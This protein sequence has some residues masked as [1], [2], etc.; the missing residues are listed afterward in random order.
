MRHTY[1]YRSYKIYIRVDVRPDIDCCSSCLFAAFVS[2]S[3]SYAWGAAAL[4]HMYDHLND[5]S[6]SGDRQ[7]CWIYGHF[8]SVAECLTDPDYDEISPRAC[9]WIAMK[10]SLKSLPASMS[11]TMGSHCGQTPTKEGGAQ[12]GYVHTIPP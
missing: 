1:A 5:A 10:T 6:K 2:Q 4:V 7:L 3:G 8:S 12:L 9:R 11:S